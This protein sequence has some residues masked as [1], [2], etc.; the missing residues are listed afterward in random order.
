MK[1]PRQSTGA[2]AADLRWCS[3]ARAYVS[4]VSADA[5]R[6]KANLHTA[7]CI[8]PKVLRSGSIRGGQRHVLPKLSCFAA[9]RPHRVSAPGCQ[10]LEEVGNSPCRLSQCRGPFH[11]AAARRSDPCVFRPPSLGAACRG[12]CAARAPLLCPLRAVRARCSPRRLG[13]PPC[14]GRPCAGTHD[15][16]CASRPLCHYSRPGDKGRTHSGAACPGAIHAATVPL[17]HKCVSTRQV[18]CA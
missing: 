14:L 16:A 6:R 12:L 13:S 9:P 17:P 5:A 8:R 2:A 4:G 15:G 10:R 11:P 7:G 18:K 1:A 3:L